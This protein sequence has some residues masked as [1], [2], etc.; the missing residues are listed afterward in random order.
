MEEMKSYHIL[1]MKFE[2]ESRHGLVDN[3]KMYIKQV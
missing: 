1:V 3:I 2:V